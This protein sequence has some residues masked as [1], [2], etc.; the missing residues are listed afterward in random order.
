MIYSWEFQGNFFSRSFIKE[1]SKT[2]M[3]RKK[4][5]LMRKENTHFDKPKKRK[6]S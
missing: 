4:A 3:T 1:N 2:K 6:L 5:I